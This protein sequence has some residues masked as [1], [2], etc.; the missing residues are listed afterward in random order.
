MKWRYGGVRHGAIG[1][2]SQ[3]FAFEVLDSWPWAKGIL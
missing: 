1:G 3:D 2:N